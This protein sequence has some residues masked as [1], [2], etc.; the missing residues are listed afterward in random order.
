MAALSL[1][2]VNNPDLHDLPRTAPSTATMKTA[3]MRCLMVG[4]V[5]SSA[6]IGLPPMLFIYSFH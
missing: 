3:M 1:T 2:Q 4:R 5:L 6:D